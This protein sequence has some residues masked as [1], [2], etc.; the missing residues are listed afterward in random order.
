MAS[1]QLSSL[2][3]S[4]RQAADEIKQCANVCDTYAKKRWLVKFFTSQLWE[5]TFI[6]LAETFVKRQENLDRILTRIIAETVVHIDH[7]VS[8]L[9][10]R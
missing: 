5:A 9:V 2:K 8:D 1:L 4:I 7:N 6:E 10:R 3:Q